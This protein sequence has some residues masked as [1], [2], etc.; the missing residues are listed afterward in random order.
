MEE[1]KRRREEVVVTR[2]WRWTHI[3]IANE[4]GN[5]IRATGVSSREE[6]INKGRDHS[7]RKITTITTQMSLQ[8]MFHTITGS[9][10]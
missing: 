8:Y 6:R 2:H 9:I 5:K 7:Q 1:T 3:E 4:M 10:K